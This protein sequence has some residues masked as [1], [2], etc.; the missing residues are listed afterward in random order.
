MDARRCN[1]GLWCPRRGI[2]TQPRRAHDGR[3]DSDGASRPSLASTVHDEK[4]TA[5]HE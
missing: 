1:V 4:P 5:Q 2:R 3:V